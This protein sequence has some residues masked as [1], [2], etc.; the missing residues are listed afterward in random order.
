M[1]QMN[2]RADSAVGAGSSDSSD[3]VNAE[4]IEALRV[5]AVA[6]IMELRMEGEERV[7]R[8]EENERLYKMAKKAQDLKA[9]GEARLRKKAEIAKQYEEMKKSWSVGSWDKGATEAEA[10]KATEPDP[11]EQDDEDSKKKKAADQRRA[12]WAAAA[13]KADKATE[14]DDQSDAEAIKAEVREKGVE[15]SAKGQ[16]MADKQRI[17]EL[18]IEGQERVKRREEYARLYRMAK[19]AQDL[20]EEGEERLR[21]KAEIA[22][23]YEEMKE[24]EESEASSEF[25]LKEV[26]MKK[27]SNSALSSWT[28]NS[29][30][31]QKESDD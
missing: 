5:E 8:R 25:I 1:L 14:L 30:F 19:K 28:K 2:L 26:L 4:R 16:Y 21:K 24:A 6:R 29:G 22:K 11:V 12:T 9:E 31:Q 3:A 10:G 20:K 7:K 17:L 27:V 23:Q 15:R 18:T 13:A